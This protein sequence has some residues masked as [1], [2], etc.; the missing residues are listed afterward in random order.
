MALNPF[1]I[2]FPG[3]DY[4]WLVAVG[5]DL[6]FDTVEYGALTDWLAPPYAELKSE[7]VSGGRAP[8]F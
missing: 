4:R 5:I 7:R 1:A 2:F 3:V 6:H 8:G